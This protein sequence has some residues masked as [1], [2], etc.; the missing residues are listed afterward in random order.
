VA[1]Q[2]VSL[3]RKR[4][5]KWQRRAQVETGFTGFLGLRTLTLADLR[6]VLG[7]IAIGLPAGAAVA[8][9]GSGSGS[10]LNCA[11]QAGES[12]DFLATMQAVTRST[13]GIS[14]LHN[15]KASLVQACSCSGV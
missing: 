9:L 3:S 12:C 13:F 10:G 7:L 14:E 1:P 15:R 8:W 2:G 6:G 4:G 5:L 11:R